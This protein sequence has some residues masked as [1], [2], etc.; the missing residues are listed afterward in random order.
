MTDASLLK[1]Q[2]EFKGI[3]TNLDTVYH[4]CKINEKQSLYIKYQ[5][6]G[7]R[8]QK[9]NHLVSLSHCNWLANRV[10]C[11]SKMGTYNSQHKP[12]AQYNTKQWRKKTNKTRRKRQTQTGNN[13][14]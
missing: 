3:K 11:N 13:D 10:N 2:K 12:K 5:K 8:K 14:Y 4:F 7:P 6:Q 1:S 9:I